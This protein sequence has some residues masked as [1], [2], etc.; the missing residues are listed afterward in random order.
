MRL[1]FSVAAHIEADVLLL[2]EVFA[3]G[4]EEFQRKCF[5][6]IHEFKSRGGTIV[7]VSHDA[8][9]V[10]RLCDRAVLLRQGAVVF[11]G[12]TARGDR[13]V[14]PAARRR[15][16]PGRARR[17]GCASGAAARR[18]S[19]RLACSTRDGD[20]R[21]PATFAAGEPCV[22]ELD[23]RRRQR[24]S[25]RRPSR[26]SCATTTV[27]C[28]AASPRRRTT[29]GWGS[30]AGRAGAAVRDRPAAARRRPLPPAVRADRS[31]RADGSSIPSTTPSASSSF[32]AGAETGAVLLEGRW[33]V[34]EIAASAPIG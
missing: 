15:A 4:D 30:G 22:V 6:K 21:M 1:G 29:L 12:S 7:F 19:S 27:S 34:Q 10:E 8:Q 13:R 31:A 11:D 5:G 25:R 24:I 23:R 17:P 20:E 3:V 18:G 28:S 32:P 33:T 9:A 16:Q 2:D 14:P 26:S